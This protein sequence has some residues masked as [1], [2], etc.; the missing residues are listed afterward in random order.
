MIAHHAPTYMDEAIAAEDAYGS[1]VVSTTIIGGNFR[2]VFPVE[3]PSQNSDAAK[4]WD[5]QRIFL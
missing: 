1:G 2:D 3:S 4:R 5:L